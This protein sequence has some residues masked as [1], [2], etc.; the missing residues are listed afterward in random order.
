MAIGLPGEDLGA[1]VDAGSAQILRVGKSNISAPYPSLTEDSPGTSGVVQTG[2]R[3]GSM[4]TGLPATDIVYRN[5]P[6]HYGEAVFAISSPFQ[7]GG[8]VDVISDDA[9]IAPRS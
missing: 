7:G 8:S 4:V 6:L 3:F 9:A 5:H 1:V 2:S